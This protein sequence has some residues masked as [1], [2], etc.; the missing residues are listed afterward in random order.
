MPVFKGISRLLNKLAALGLLLAA[1]ALPVLLVGLPVWSRH[2][3]SADDVASG[4]A[5]LG[6]LQAAVARERAARTGAAA[7]AQPDNIFFEADS[8]LALQATL[9]ARLV[10]IA[11]AEKLQLLSS[12]QLPAHASGEAKVTGVRVNFRTDMAA[13]Q[14]MLHAIEGA[15]PL[16]F[17]EVADLRAELAPA[18]APVDAAPMIDATLDV[19]GTASPAITANADSKP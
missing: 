4:L 5:D 3:Q 6:K 12:S 18:S 19:F 10:A 16:M 13:V 8:E 15:R 11:Q 1:L 7:V 2:Q 14:R 9:Q 17:V